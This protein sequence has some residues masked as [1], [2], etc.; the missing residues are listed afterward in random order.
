MVSPSTPLVSEVEANILTCLEAF[1]VTV[2]SITRTTHQILMLDELAT[3]KRPHWDD[4]TDKFQGTCRE[5]NHKIPLKFS[6]QKE[7]DIL[8]QA[9]G[10]GEVHLACEVSR[11]FHVPY[12]L[13]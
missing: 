1:S 13:L 10:N 3:E 11:N 6:S 9:L 5:H 2:G 8:F 7:L 12:T 4:L